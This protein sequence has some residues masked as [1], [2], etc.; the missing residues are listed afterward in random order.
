MD[1]YKPPRRKMVNPLQNSAFKKYLGFSMIAIF[2]ILAFVFFVWAAGGR[3]KGI[4]DEINFIQLDTPEDDAPVVVF[5]TNLGTLKAEVF[6]E[7]VPNYYQYF[8]QLV[9][10]G[11]YDGT[12]VCAVVDGA[13]ALGGTKKPNP[14]Q[15][16]GEDSDTTQI[17]A[18]V[19][20]DLWPLKGAICSFIGSSLGKNYAGSSMIFINDLSDVND[21]YMNEDALKR[22]YGDEL[23]GKFAEVGGIPNFSQ[24]YTIFAQIYDG[25]DVFE[26]ICSAEVLESSQ[27]ASDIYFEKVYFSTY[28]EEKSE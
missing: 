25:W 16:Y 3:Q 21:A 19:S 9:D 17:R 26:K 27:P 14:D 13:Y 11:Y 20:D 8:R 18:E 5:E 28:G 12:Y 1:D 4:P 6:P 15:E 22:A 24:E 23:G 7:Q 10:S 2:V